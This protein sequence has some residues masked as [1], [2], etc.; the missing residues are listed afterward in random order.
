MGT[1]A[2][3]VI[4][5][6]NGGGGVLAI[7][8]AIGV[9]QAVLAGVAAFGVLAF[10]VRSGTVMITSDTFVDVRTVYPTATVATG[11]S[12]TEAAHGVGTSGVAV[13]VVGAGRT[14]V[15]IRAAVAAP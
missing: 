14:F 10:L 11:A 2:N 9:L 7:D 15:H 5:A 8:S 4:A 6:A 12:A 1:A 13:T 3:A